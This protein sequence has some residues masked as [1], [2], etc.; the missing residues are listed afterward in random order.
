MT[1][2]EP[3]VLLTDTSTSVQMV[4]ERKSV[5]WPKS[6]IY[7]HGLG[8]E[9]AGLVWEGAKGH[10]HEAGYKLSIRSAELRAMSG[11]QIRDAGRQIGEAVSLLTPA[12]LPIQRGQPIE[13]WFRAIEPG[14]EDEDFKGIAINEFGSMG[15]GGSE[16]KAAIEG[17]PSEIQ[18]QLNAAVEK[19]HRYQ[20]QI[21]LVLLDF[22]SEDLWEDDIPPMM[23]NIQIPDGIDEI[24]RTTRDW[25]SADDYEVGYDR[26]YKR[27]S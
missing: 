14:E 17:I 12:D 24:W 1:P 20:K 6:Y 10:F 23:Q 18:E 22:Y 27:S 4:I 8:H 16:R 11:K 3:E 21:K 7:Q 13:W 26:L 5:V 19:F 2:K 9:F 25:V 15:L